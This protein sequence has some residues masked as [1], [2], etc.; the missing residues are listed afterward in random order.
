[1][2]ETDIKTF[3]AGIGHAELTGRLSKPYPHRFRIGEAWLRT[4]MV[5]C[6]GSFLFLLCIDVV[7]SALGR[8]EARSLAMLVGR[9]WIAVPAT[10]VFLVCLAAT[11][12]DLLTYRPL[13]LQDGHYEALGFDFIVHLGT[14][15]SIGMLLRELK[16]H[17]P[18]TNRGAL[19]HEL[20][21]FG[22]VWKLIERRN[23]RYK[24]ITTYVGLLLTLLVSLT[25]FVYFLNQSCGGSLLSGLA[26]GSPLFSHFYFVVSTFFTIG[27]G[28]IRPQK[29]AFLGEFVV[30]IIAFASL[31]SLYVGLGVFLTGLHGMRDHLRS[32]VRSFVVSRCH[33]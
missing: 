27:N 10:V 19:E 28:D 18:R 32:A 14:A 7:A 5:I 26:D 29:G 17:P 30:I 16:T 2:P 12:I 21:I 3:L 15:N 9:N 4:N 24:I 6:W 33:L 22:E 23:V 25:L 11:I 20:K 1:M 31:L 13:I 8:P